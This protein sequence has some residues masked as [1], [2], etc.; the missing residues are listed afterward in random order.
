M[1]VESDSDNPKVEGNN[2]AF[3]ENSGRTLSQAGPWY[4]AIKAKK[5]NKARTEHNGLGQ[6]QPG[7]P[8]TTSHL[9]VRASMQDNSHHQQCRGDRR[10]SRPPMRRMVPPLPDSEYKVVYLP[11]TGMNVCSSPDEKITEGIARANHIR[12]IYEAYTGQIIYEVTP[13]FKPLPGTVRGVV[14]GITAGTTEERLAELLAANQCGILHA[15]RLGK[16]TS[17]VITFQGP[18]VPF[19]IK[20]ASSFTRCRPYRRS[21]QYCKVCGDIGHRQDICPNPDA[22]IC[23]QCGVRNP[24]EGHECKLECKLCG[25]AHETASKECVRRLKPRLRPLH[26]RETSKS[27][28]IQP[29]NN[30]ATNENRAHIE[31][32]GCQLIDI[33]F[34]PSHRFSSRSRSQSRS[35]RRSRSRSANKRINSETTKSVE[36]TTQYGQQKITW[37][38]HTANT[39]SAAAHFPMLTQE[40]NSRY[41][42]T[43]S[44]LRRQI[45]DLMEQNENLLKRLDEQQRHQEER[46]RRAQIR[47]QTPERKIQQLL[48]QMQKHTESSLTAALSTES[49]H[50]IGDHEEGIEFKMHKARA[51]DKAELRREFQTEL[52]HAVDSIGKS[53]ASAVQAALQTLRQQIAH[54]ANDLNERI[55]VLEKDE[56]QGR[57]KPKYPIREAQMKDTLGSKDGE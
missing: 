38:P 47:E 18:H 30:T 13:Y 15:R 8:N 39:P 2:A 4:Q 27:N 11:R 54:M 16:S 28:D 55:S 34:G 49:T 14:H 53:V 56:E 52:A 22:T 25:L 31:S 46:D 17:A 43:I 24:Q 36:S 26:V 41:E 6:N 10:N 5:S 40:R 50:P 12:G 20:V 42:D 29:L 3:D 19:S 35:R 23:S 9:T 57:K 7:G 37:A 32:E 51:E 1:D 33:I 44:S 21:V 45:A 48:E